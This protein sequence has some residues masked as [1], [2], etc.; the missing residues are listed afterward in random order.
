M[1]DIFIHINYFNVINSRDND[2]CELHSQ[3]SSSCEKYP[4]PGPASLIL[5][6]T[7]ALTSAPTR[8]HLRLASHRLMAWVSSLRTQAAS[9]PRDPAS[10]QGCSRHSAAL[11]LLLGLTTIKLLISSLASRLTLGYCSIL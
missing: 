8:A 5:I 3:T 11:N 2:N 1:S 6:L 4:G 10:S 7:V 9:V